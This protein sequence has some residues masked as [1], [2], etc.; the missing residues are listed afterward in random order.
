MHAASQART[1]TRQF[2]SMQ[3]VFGRRFSKN[4]KTLENIDFFG[5]LPFQKNTDKMF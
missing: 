2:G 3:A 4:S 5:F 1:P